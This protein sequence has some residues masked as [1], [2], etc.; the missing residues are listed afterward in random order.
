[1]R[2]FGDDPLLILRTQGRLLVATVR[3]MALLLPAFVI[4]AIPLAF[5]WDTLD[6]V[7]GRAAIEPGDAVV[8]TA[9]LN[10]NSSGTPRLI[11]PDWLAVESPAVHAVAASEVCWRLRVVRAGSGNVEAVDGPER[12]LRKI[13]ARPGLHYLPDRE[14]A[15][16]GP[17][18]WL[19]LR[20]PP[21]DIAAF[22]V[23]AR[24]PV[25]FFAISTVTALVFRRRLRVTL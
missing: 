9:R 25:W 16:G 22:G 1:M 14:Q 24:W 6:A 3:Y 11:V 23:S 15:S 18:L 20:Y 2:L 12:A 5:A 10:D 13:E 21:A 19:E 7:W 4:V 8:L 17:I